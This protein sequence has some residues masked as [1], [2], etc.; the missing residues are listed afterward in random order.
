MIAGEVQPSPDVP[1]SAEEIR[2]YAAQ[3]QDRTR[4][5]LSILNRPQDDV[6]SP[7]GV[8]LLVGADTLR[9]GSGEPQRYNS[10][11]LLDPA[12]RVVDRYFK[13]HLV[14]FGEYI[15]L[16]SVFPWLYGLTP[17][18]SG[19]TPGER[20]QVFGVAGLRISP[21]ICFE[22]TVPHLIRRQV[23]ALEAAGEGPD[24]LINVT[25]DGW[26]W[27]SAILDLHLACAVFRAVENRCPMLVA[28][29]TGLSAHIDANGK[30]LARGPRRAEAVILAEVHPGERGSWYR[31]VGDV[32]AGLC[33]AFGVFVAI[34]GLA[35]RRLRPKA[36]ER[37]E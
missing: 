3:F 22:S 23:A 27:G 34:V 8:H 18:P 32:P 36:G 29:N 16:G 14:M 13:M 26:F 15:P 9:F 25:N 35:G 12:G 11:L 24:L 19:L 37:L 30:V 17:M 2:D 31:R 6:P 4:Q 33:L 5:T 1:L 28:A 7:A 21:S 20:P 10:A